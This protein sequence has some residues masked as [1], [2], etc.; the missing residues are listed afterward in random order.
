MCNEYHLACTGFCVCASNYLCILY[1]VNR[2]GVLKITSDKSRFE[3]LVLVRKFTTRW[4]NGRWWPFVSEHCYTGMRNETEA[5]WYCDTIVHVDLFLLYVSGKRSRVW[6]RSKYFPK[7]LLLCDLI[8]KRRL[9]F[10]GELLPVVDLLT[11]Q[12]GLKVDVV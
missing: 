2:R 9:S 12:S 7:C 10:W 3:F 5:S 1:K 4:G 8:P 11:C 6:H